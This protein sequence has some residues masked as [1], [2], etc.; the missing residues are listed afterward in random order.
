MNLLLWALYFFSFYAFL[1]AFISR[2]FGFR[3]FKK[4]KVEREIALTFDDGPDPEYTPQLLDLLARYK[5]KAT[6]FVVGSHAEKHP[7]LLRRM[8][9]EGHIIGIHNY[10]HKSNWLMRPRTVRKQIQQTA[11]IIREATGAD[12]VFYRPP[13]GIVNVFDYGNLGHYQIVLWSSMFGDWRSA[14]GADKLKQRMMEKLRPGEIVLLHDCGRTPGADADAPA[15]MLI[16]LE[17]Y[18]KEGANRGYRFIGVREMM[19]LSELAKNGAVSSKS[20]PRAVAQPPR[21]SFWKRTVI[22]LWLLYEKAFHVVYGLKQVGDASPAFHY[23]VKKYGGE[24]V[25]LSN[26]EQLS[27]GDKIVELH[28][29]NKKLSTIAAQSKSPLAT[30]IRILR[31]VEQALPVLANTIAGDPDARAAKSIYGVTMVYRGANKLGFQIVNLPDGLFARS[32]RIY[33]RVLMR[34]LTNK[35]R[36]ARAKE[37]RSTIDPK[38]LLMPIGNLLVLATTTLQDSAVKLTEAV[39]R[40]LHAT[41]EEPSQAGGNTTAI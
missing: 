10:V 2:T 23:R 37:R 21:Q 1:P 40:A 35:Q 18:L 39:D 33:L 24:A 26:G 25:E 7:E 4:G 15:Q 14:L 13:W 16:A 30:G 28:F 3:V 41:V 11:D 29:D 20:E 9:E 22:R 5:A 38:M 27:K 36:N 19:E 12:S 34:V 8:H 31:E 6:F 17:A 32:S